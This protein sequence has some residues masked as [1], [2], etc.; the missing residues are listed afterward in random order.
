MPESLSAM[1]LSVIIPTKDE[2]RNLPELLPLLRRELS[3]HPH[4]IIVVDAGSQDGTL[5]TA[6]QY[7][8]TLAVQAPK[9]GR[10]TQQNH[11]AA[12]ATGDTLYF[13]HADTRPPAG[14]HADIADSLAQGFEAGCYRSSYDTRN[15]FMKFNAWLTRF[16]LLFLRGG[17]QSIFVKR[18]RF[19]EL[20]GFRPDYLIMEDF[21][22]LKRLRE[23][24]AFRV[25]PKD[26]LIS[27]RKYNHNSYVR[28]NLANILVVTMYRFGASQ[29]RLVE[30]YRSWLRPY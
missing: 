23:A 27:A 30:T 22:F 26:I 15:P 11:G 17:D 1:K 7:G 20:G 18:T 6:R 16:D 5:E 4:E 21:E 28:V 9:P 10:A 29:Q 19:H 2:A 24:V 25:I 8:A 3:G 14:F 12:L 13:V